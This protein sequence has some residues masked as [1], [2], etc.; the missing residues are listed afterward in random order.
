VITLKAGGSSTQRTAQASVRGGN[1]DDIT[2]REPISNDWPAIL[3]LAEIALSELPV[4]PSQRE[5]LEN[6]RSLAQ[7]GG[8]Q[9]HFVAASG[10]RIV[11]YACAERCNGAADGVYRVFVVVAPSARSTVGTMLLARLRERLLSLGARSAWFLEYE[12]D[13][14][15]ISYLEDLGFVKVTGFKLDDG[16]PLVRLTMDA[17]FQSLAQLG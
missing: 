16:T 15:F 3:S 2:L 17:P 13:T 9:R 1:M 6:R 14:G 7:S 11:G 5:W 10:E 12:S 8:I 4:V